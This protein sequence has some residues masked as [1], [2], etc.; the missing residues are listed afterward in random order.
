MAKYNFK[1]NDTIEMSVAHVPIAVLPYIDIIYLNSLSLS[2]P[3]TQI[4]TY[5]HTVHINTQAYTPT[6]FRFKRYEK[7]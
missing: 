5:T 3:P 1:V 7:D 6:V 4:H 2:L